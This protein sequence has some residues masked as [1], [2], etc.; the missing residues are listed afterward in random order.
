M[1]SAEFLL[2]CNLCFKELLANDFFV[3]CCGV[4]YCDSC[5]VDYL[6]VEGNAFQCQ[7]CSSFSE[8]PAGF[9]DQRKQA[10]GLTSAS[11]VSTAA[12]AVTMQPAA[13]AV[14]TM[15]P[16]ATT[17]SPRQVS[18]IPTYLLRP[19]IPVRSIWPSK[20]FTPNLAAARPIAQDARAVDDGGNKDE[21]APGEAIIMPASA[22]AARADTARNSHVNLPAVESKLEV[23]GEVDGAKKDTIPRAKVKAGKMGKKHS[24]RQ[25]GPAAK[26]AKAEDTDDDM[27][28]D[29]E[30]TVAFDQRILAAP[31]SS[32]NKVNKAATPG[33]RQV[34]GSELYATLPGDKCHA[35][36]AG[37]SK[38]ACSASATRPSNSLSYEIG[39]SSGA[40][41]KFISIILVFF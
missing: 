9:L 31:A 14:V 33:K 28:S 7:I 20:K 34:L 22:T 11:V 41:V 16:A 26:N 23:A 40:Q 35:Q 37:P 5:V 39:Q 3:S 4:T 30:D 29:D 17:A 38:K 25:V 21:R 12:A 15:Q 1:N 24:T 13:T 2:E 8:L 6:H 10:I 36:A 19:G 18:P 32:V 27:E